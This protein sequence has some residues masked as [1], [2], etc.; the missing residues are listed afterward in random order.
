M[1]RAQQL[2]SNAKSDE[3]PDLDKNGDGKAGA[4]GSAESGGVLL[5]EEISMNR[6]VDFLRDQQ[7]TSNQRETEFIFEKQQMATRIN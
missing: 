1:S 7:K 6:I 5:G 2:S 3:K 4:K